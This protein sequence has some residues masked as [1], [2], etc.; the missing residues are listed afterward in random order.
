ME[1]VDNFEDPVEK[2]SST[3]YA[4]PEYNIISGVKKGTI[5]SRDPDGVTHKQ[6]LG[7]NSKDYI[8]M[9]NF[10]YWDHDLKE[11]LDPTGLAGL[12]HSRRLGAERILNKSDA[13]TRD[14]LLKVLIDHSVMAK[15]TI[16]QAIINVEKDSYQT[17]LPYCE[18]C[19]GCQDLDKCRKPKEICCGLREHYTLRCAV[20]GNSGYRC[21]ALPDGACRSIHLNKNETGSDAD[22]ESFTS[23]FTLACAPSNRRCGPKPSDSQEGILV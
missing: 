12:G 15:D 5:L 20:P 13:I 23:H 10:D 22:C 2:F 19:A 7:P 18:A 16:F 9:T 17:Q 21:G 8:I 14:L 3:P 4:A 6:V 1:A 11:W